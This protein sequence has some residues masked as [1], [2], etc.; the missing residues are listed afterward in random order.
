MCNHPDGEYSRFLL[1]GI[2]QGF[3]IRFDYSA[4][5]CTSPRRNMKSASVPPESIDRY[6]KEELAVGHII[7]PLAAEF[8]DR[9]QIGRF[10]VIPKPH[11]PKKWRLIT[12]LSFPGRSRDR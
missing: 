3:W 9:I 11:L 4:H 2:H 12:D 5:S 1:G 10:G 7:G 8:R 6:I